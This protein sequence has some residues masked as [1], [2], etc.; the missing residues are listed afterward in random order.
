MTGY[1][2]RPFDTS[3]LSLIEKWL[4]APH[5][6][7]W[8]G[9]PAREFEQIKGHLTRSWMECVIVELSG[10]PF[11]YI[12]TYDLDSDPEREWKEL[13][14]GARGLDLFIGEAALIGLGHGTAMLR[15]FSDSLL[16]RA[17]V[18]SVWSDPDP[19]NDASIGAFVAAGFDDMGLR[20][21]PWGTVRLMCKAGISSIV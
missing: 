9:D 2:F 14:Q 5:V 7:K 18:L 21:M 15:S 1:V 6:R 12:Q 11:A 8:W 13:P 17:G 10:E 3:H 19:A 4:N 16:S 20:E